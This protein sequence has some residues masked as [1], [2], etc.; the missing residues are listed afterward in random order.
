VHPP[1]VVALAD[2][3]V[4]NV[5][6]ESESHGCFSVSFQLFERTLSMSSG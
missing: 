6:I 3:H 5:Q 1:V 2:Q 4:R